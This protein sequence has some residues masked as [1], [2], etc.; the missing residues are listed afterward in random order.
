MALTQAEVK[1]LTEL[2][3]EMT[4]LIEDPVN[5]SNE[6]AVI[7]GRAGH[8][9]TRGLASHAAAEAKKSKRAEGAGK[10]KASRQVRMEKKKQKGGSAG[11]APAATSSSSKKSA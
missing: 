9:F 3:D 11:P 2:S 5:T 7:W 4:K 10:F 6:A 1:R 8:I